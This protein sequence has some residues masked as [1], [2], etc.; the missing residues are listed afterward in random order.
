LNTVLLYITSR[1]KVV[2]KL[3]PPGSN[4]ERAK[5]KLKEISKTAFLG[6]II[7]PD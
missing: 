2:A 5:S 3:I 7:T 4:R 1:G 6:D